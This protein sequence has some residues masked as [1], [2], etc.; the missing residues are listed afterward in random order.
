MSE[1][2][3]PVQ[4]VEVFK[5]TDHM[6]KALQNKCPKIIVDNTTNPHYAGYLLGIQHALNLIKEGFTTV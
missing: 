2:T 4:V 5:L 6:F 1:E 3:Q